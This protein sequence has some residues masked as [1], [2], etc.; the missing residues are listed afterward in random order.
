MTAGRASSL[1]RRLPAP[2][3]RRLQR[4][5]GPPNRIVI[6]A[7]IVG[8]VLLGTAFAIEDAP[9]ALLIAA[10]L[11]IMTLPSIVDVDGP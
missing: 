9:R 11:A 3:A 1:T 5:A 6:P 2:A 7:L 8:G 4:D 10:G